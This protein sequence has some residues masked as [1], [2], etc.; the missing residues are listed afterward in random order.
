MESKNPLRHA[1]TNISSITEIFHFHGFHF[2]PLKSQ[3]WNNFVNSV[4]LIDTTS[5]QDDD[6]TLSVNDGHI[7]EVCKSI[8]YETL[9]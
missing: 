4:A 3:S 6:G 7:P 9:E 5:L 2:N 1:L 8:L